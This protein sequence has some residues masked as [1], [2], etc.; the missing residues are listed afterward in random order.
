M[1][2]KIKLKHLAIIG[3]LFSFSCE[4]ELEDCYETVCDGADN[5]NCHEEPV[6]NS[7]CFPMDGD[8]Q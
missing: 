6:F 3:I 7:G 1:K 4:G 5:T 2:P 8:Q